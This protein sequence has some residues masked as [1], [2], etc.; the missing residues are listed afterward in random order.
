MKILGSKEKNMQNNDKKEKEMETSIKGK[1]YHS[2]S[3]A[4]KIAQDTKK[5]KNYSNYVKKCRNNANIKDFSKLVAKQTTVTEDDKVL[6]LNEFEKMRMWVK[7]LLSIYGTIPN[8]IRIIDQII[9]RQAANPFAANYGFNAVDQFD[10]IVNYYDRKNKLLN[11]NIMTEK[12]VDD[13]TDDELELVGLKFEEKVTV[14]EIASMLKIER[15]SV[16]R[17]LDRIVNKLTNNALVRGWSTAFVESQLEDEP[18]VE[19]RYKEIYR[20]YLLK[21]R[22]MSIS[23]ITVDKSDESDSSEPELNR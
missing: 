5:C 7:T 16:Y 12:M 22:K 3:L 13:L 9:E 11:I 18:W 15:R 20:D 21:S 2:C 4:V 19:E 8:I 6:V 23:Q 1:N 17:K 14:D 10:K